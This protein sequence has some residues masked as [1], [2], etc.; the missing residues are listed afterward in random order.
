L[1]N[2]SDWVF[3]DE[4]S[5]V[6]PDA[7]RIAGSVFNIH[8]KRHTETYLSADGESQ[9]SNWRADGSRKAAV[10]NK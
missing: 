1:R 6:F 2:G 10:V 5:E 9:N 7:G 4:A 3:G 8:F